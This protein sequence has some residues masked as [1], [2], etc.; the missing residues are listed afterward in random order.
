[1]T[2]NVVYVVKWCPL[3]NY[4]KWLS[5]KSMQLQWCSVRCNWHKGAI[6]MKCDSKKK[7]CIFGPISPP[8]LFCVLCTFKVTQKPELHSTVRRPKKTRRSIKVD[9]FTLS[10]NIHF[11]S[12]CKRF[13]Q[14]MLCLV[15]CHLWSISRPEK[16]SPSPD[17]HHYTDEWWQTSCWFS[18]WELVEENWRWLQARHV[19]LKRHS[20]EDF[21]LIQTKGTLSLFSQLEILL[22]LNLSNLD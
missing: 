15:T 16:H 8:V 13:Y 5:P 17:P 21:F 9:S 3:W 22:A 6:P 2:K 20:N 10:W 12:V 7:H 14:R 4:Y 11:S 1:M 18:I 19:L